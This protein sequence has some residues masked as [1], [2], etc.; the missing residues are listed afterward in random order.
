MLEFDVEIA[1]IYLQGSVVRPTRRDLIS[2]H[3]R[4]CAVPCELQLLLNTTRNNRTEPNR[5]AKLAVV[6]SLLLVLRSGTAFHCSLKV[7]NLANI[8]CVT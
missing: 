1:G 6:H 2:L 5:T 3:R 8:S 4:H 7:F